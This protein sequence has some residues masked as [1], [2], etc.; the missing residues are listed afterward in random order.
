MLDLFLDY[1]ATTNNTYSH[2]STALEM[3]TSRKK[4]GLEWS[5]ARDVLLV[6]GM[7]MRTADLRSTDRLHFT[8]NPNFAVSQLME[9]V[10]NT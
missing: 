8:L 9:R 7:F 10:H 5:C 4:I 6:T 1:F 2:I 3:L